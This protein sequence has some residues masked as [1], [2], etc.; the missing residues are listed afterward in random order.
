[1]KRNTMPMKRMAEFEAEYEKLVLPIL[2][3]PGLDEATTF[4]AGDKIVNSI[5]GVLSDEIEKTIP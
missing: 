1:M 5:R 2:K 4:I 3:R